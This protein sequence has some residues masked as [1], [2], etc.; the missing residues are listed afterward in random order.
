MEPSTQESGLAPRLETLVRQG[1]WLGKLNAAW[2]QGQAARAAVLGGVSLLPGVVGWLTN[3]LQL[4]LFLGAGI[5]ASLTLAMG[6]ALI[7]PARAPEK[8]KA[9]QKKRK[10][11]SKSRKPA[12]IPP[13]AG[14]KFVG[15]LLIIA[16][17]AVIVGVFWVNQLP[18]A[19]PS[20][21]AGPPASS[22]RAP[23]PTTSPVTSTV[24]A[25]PPTNPPVG[26]DP[27]ASH[28]SPSPA[29][30]PVT[31]TA[32]AVPQGS[33]E[34]PQEG[35]I[36]EAKVPAHGRVSGLR[37]GHQLILLLLYGNGTCYFPD[38]TQIAGDYWA[39]ESQAGGDEAKGL[40]FTLNL[41]DIGPN[42]VTALQQ[43]QAEERTSGE[44]RG[45]C[46]RQELANEYEATILASVH[47]TRAP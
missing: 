17:V 3:I 34:E 2:P 33:F 19:N 21:A 18:L 32:L 4:Y 30:P 5:P 37:P 12:V 26:D 47:I 41:A 45:I 43:Y 6:V 10:S 42:G 7:R 22:S 1:N 44:A 13:S 31:S 40:P 25:A 28:P 16:S 39:G 36:V 27:P 20:A 38:N 9:A 14:R 24:L 46:D 8:P 29:P 23:S 35:A 15:W 11:A